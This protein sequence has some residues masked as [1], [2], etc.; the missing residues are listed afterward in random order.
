MICPKCR[1]DKIVKNGTI[2]NGKPKFKCNNCNR[3]F[4]ENTK[5]K[6]IS[7]DIKRIIDKLLLERISLAGICRVTGVSPDWWYLYIKGQYAQTPKKCSVRTKNKGKLAI[8]IDELWSFVGHKNNKKWVWIAL[9]QK[10][11]E[12][13][14]LHLG[15][16]SQHSAKAWWDSLP[17]VYRQCAVC[18]TD[19]L[20]SYSGVLPQ[21]RHRPVDNN[22]GK[23]NLI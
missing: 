7:L 18:Y 1:S 15:D 9:D 12:I 8:Q 4:V 5:N 17:A 22:S 19:F 6:Q 14:G 10:T 13:V 23:M 3:Q 20:D 21:K 11:R 2:H 16:R